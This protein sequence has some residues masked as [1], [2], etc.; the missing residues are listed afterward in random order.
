MKRLN[1]LYRHVCDKNNIEL[2]DDCAR[3]GKHNWGIKKHDLHRESDNQ[4]LLESLI[5]L[6]YR[7][8]EYDRFKI[9]EPKERIIFRLPYF[10]DRI[11]QWDIML[12]ME[13]IWVKTFISQTYS[14]I[15]DRGIH[16]LAKDVKK[17]LRTDKQGTQ[18]CLKLDVR[19]FYP[20]IDHEILKYDILRRKIKDKKLL[21]ILDEIVDSAEGVPIGNYLSQFFANL[22]LSYF[23][24]W[25]KEEIG[26]K[27]Y[28][29][30]ADDIVILSDDK[31][32][33]RKVLILIKIYFHKILNLEVKP[34]Y[35]I[36]PVDSRGIDF[37]GYVF[38][39]TH[40][41]V[42]KSI[43]QRIFRLINRYKAGKIDLEELKRRLTFYFGW[44]KYCDSKNLLQKIE[45]ETGLHFSNWNGIEAKVSD[46]YGKNVR[47][48][49]IVKY[50]KYF[51]IHFIYKHKPFTVKSRS[52]RLYNTLKN[53]IFPLNFKLI[54][55][56]GTKK[57]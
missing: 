5:D 23:D 4:K 21:T 12:T 39:H 15:K 2:A 1:N 22:F 32:K 36:F 48:I 29:R 20:S 50:S 33:L 56:A 54:S 45:R 19:K 26:I 8:S 24:H 55:Y 31:E 46:F 14:C 47:I 38:F 43:K 27:H 44:L 11:A 49:E 7:T 25:L 41:L 52:M 13:P 17:A 6:S 30:Y 28:F 37:A 42:R 57:N 16:K 18:Y 10:P 3:R 35:Q 51:K 9:F 34:N 53:C 40:T